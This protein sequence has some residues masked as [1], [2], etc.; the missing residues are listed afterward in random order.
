MMQERID[1]VERRLLP[2]NHTKTLDAARLLDIPLLCAHTPADNQ[3]ASFLQRLIAKKRPDT[4]GEILELLKA[5]PEY[6]QAMRNNAGPK[7]IH[8][9]G[10]SRCGKVFV[11]M[12]GG[13]EGAKDIF[14]NLAQAGVGTIVGMHLSED[15]LKQAKKA[16]VNVIIAGHISSDTLGL[17]LLIDGIEK[18][19]P[20][21]IVDCSG[22]TR[23]RRK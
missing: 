19:Q 17:N 22:F 13:T 3:V 6:Q 16:W 2:V 10:A 18:K 4:V 1:E 21:Q 15:H 20:F 8:G 9:S 23:I 12:T 5:I 14:K 11:D 7:I